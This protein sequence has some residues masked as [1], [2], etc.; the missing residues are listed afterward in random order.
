[1][2]SIKA[3]VRRPSELLRSLIF[4]SPTSLDHPLA[5]KSMEIKD[6]AGLT[7]V[8]NLDLPT[9]VLNCLLRANINNLETVASMSD[10]DLLNIVGFGPK[11]LIELKECLEN[12]KTS[13][14]NG[15]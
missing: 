4:R 9:R 15:K 6:T 2:K 1:M 5:D 14:G 13:L 7:L 12:Y 11:A 3:L 10:E 8:N